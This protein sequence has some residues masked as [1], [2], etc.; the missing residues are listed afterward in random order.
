MILNNRERFYNIEAHKKFNKNTKDYFN[1]NS[2]HYD[3]NIRA[4][5]SG[6]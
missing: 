5:L 2:T 4:E 1:Y 6:P 3:S